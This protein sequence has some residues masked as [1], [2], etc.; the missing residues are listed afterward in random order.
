MPASAD[1]VVIGGGVIGLSTAYHLAAAG[2]QVVL[3]ERGALGEG[4]TCR[5]AGGVRGFFSDAINIELGLRGL[6]VFERFGELF[7]TEIDL[8]RSGYLFLVDNP[9]DLA[10]FER[11]VALHNSLGGQSRMITA[12]EAV[13]LSPLVDPSGLLGAAGSPRD[14]HCTPEAV[15]A[16]YAKAAR[17]AGARVLTHCAA[18][19]IETREG[20]V[21]AVTTEAGRIRT[22]AVVCAAG[23]WSATVGRWAGVDLP[24]SPLRRQ[25]A[26]TGP[27]E[28]AVP[29]LPA[30][31]PF[32]I[33]F[34]TSFYFHREGPGLL[35][36]SSEST[37]SWSFDLTRDPAWLTDLAE[38]MERRVPALG[39]VGI[40]G[41][42]AG[43]YEVTPDHNAL[44][45]RSEEVP[46]FVYACGFSGH[47][48]L[49]GPAVGEVVR[50][51]CLGQ[52]PVLDVRDLSADRFSTAGI[53][54][55]L[56][57]V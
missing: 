13:R 52:T 5:A 38:M 10:A 27:L 1:V 17:A 30:E 49:M 25:I 2:Q 34:S 51:L 43:L 6:E 46:G 18:T 47:G 23:A 24:V 44:I 40:A 41:G 11:N 15:V 22:D 9:E 36:G 33:D 39:E 45:G 20:Q 32:T 14:G 53:R 55:E 31:V 54:P 29:D 26:V 4:S 42:W 50:D 7:D 3:L 56:N 57:I 37:D 12:E 35:L 21:T 28:A 48:F 16:G 8:H 19:G